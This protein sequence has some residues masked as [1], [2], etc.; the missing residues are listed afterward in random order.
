MNK[1]I[2]QFVSFNRYES[3]V[4][5]TLLDKFKIDEISWMKFNSN[6]KHAKYFQ[7]ENQ[8]VWW[9]LMRWLFEDFLISVMRCYFYV[10]E[11]Q[12]EYSKIYF[13]RKNIWCIVITLSEQDLLRET[14]KIVEK[15]EM[16]AQCENHNFAPGK[17]R[18]IPK[19]ETFRP[20]MTFNRKVPHSKT[21]TTNKKLAVAHMMLKNLKTKMFQN[22]F[23]FAVFNYDDIMKKY[24]VFVKKWKEANKPKL[25]F[26]TMDIEKCYDNVDA[27]KVAGFLNRSDLIEKEYYIL[28]CIVL[29]RKNNI[30]LEQKTFKKQPIKSYF[31][32]KFHKIG[33]DG[34]Q[35]P[36]L[37]EILSEENDFNLKRTVI[38]E[39]ESRKKYLKK[40]LLAPISYICSNNYIT[41]NKKQFKQLKGI[42][43]GLCLSYVL[44]SFYYANL[45]ENALHFIKK[46]TNKGELNLLMRLTDDYLLMTSSKNNAMLVIEQLQKLSQTNYF[47]LNMKK[48]KTSF[49]INLKK[50]G[51]HKT[52]DLSL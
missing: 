11:K 4:R 12:K 43:Q 19:G 13:Y 49:P 37:W 6:H 23:G 2:F 33:V 7:L 25:Y 29:K 28:S 27:E 51:C 50:I 31:R 18:L 8:F 35:Y 9:R 30:I 44:S 14:L 17:L 5:T 16:Q 48:L 15:K 36:S 10:T 39:Q 21:L 52:N 45:E 32:H 3:F 42:P 22:D 40:D 46:E 1:K 38:V 34:G 20:I 47:K 24:E 26:V 41:F